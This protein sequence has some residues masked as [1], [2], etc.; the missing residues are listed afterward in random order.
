MGNHVRMLAMLVALGS[1]FVVGTAHA[2][3][4]KCESQGKDRHH[5][6]V[7]IGRARVELRDRLS[8]H[9]CKQGKSW[10]YDEDGIWVDDGCRAEF[11]IIRRGGGYGRH[12]DDDDDDRGTSDG[13]MARACTDAAAR[14]YDVGA[15]H[16]SLR[17]VENE[18]DGYRI[19]GHAVQERDGAKK[20]TCIF[21][22]H[23][24]LK[25]V[26]ANTSDGD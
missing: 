25:N 5:C 14:Q 1:M 17:R 3:R 16:V 13:D 12:D 26:E 9:T 24:K 2:E 4:I 8:D 6:K 11:E 7:D 23:R 18:G 21:N 15:S 22:K 19:S 20:F 10:D